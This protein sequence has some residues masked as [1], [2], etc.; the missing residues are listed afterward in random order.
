MSL[1]LHSNRAIQTQLACGACPGRE[2]AVPGAD[3][4]VGHEVEEGRGEAKACW[5][6]SDQEARYS[7]AV[8]PERHSASRER[9]KATEG[10]PRRLDFA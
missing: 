10:H 5:N 8:Y 7:R 4:D 2:E 6:H 9:W 1:Y 3:A